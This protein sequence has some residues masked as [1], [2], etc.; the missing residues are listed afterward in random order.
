MSSRERSPSTNRPRNHLVTDAAKP[1]EFVYQQYGKPAKIVVHQTPNEDTWPGGALWDI[2]V[3]LSHVMVGLG[4][5][6]L[7]SSFKSVSL[8]TR[9]FQAIE[10]TNSN[11]K[12]DWTVLELGCGVGLTGLVAAAVLGTQLTILTD[13]KVVVD[14]VTQP[15]VERNSVISAGGKHKPYRLMNTGKRGRVMAMPLCWGLEEDE[16]E[17]A[18]IL[19]QNTT[20]AAKPKSSR[21]SKKKKATKDHQCNKGV[22][23]PQDDSSKPSLIII[24]D[25]AYQHKPGAPSHFDALVSTLL[26]FLGHNTLVIFGTRMR[27]PASADL[28]GMFSKHMEECCAP[29]PADEIDQSFGK[30]KHQITVHVFRRRR[31]GTIV[32]A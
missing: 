16:K 27:M 20:T 11:N 19:R 30:F 15:N 14:K 13:L 32:P 8:P 5:G 25:V 4:S 7:S 17:V 12:A 2:G 3:L 21:T 22:G 29:I 23:I 31:E 28:L 1:F 6:T 18:T 26:K 10:S 9:L 24:G